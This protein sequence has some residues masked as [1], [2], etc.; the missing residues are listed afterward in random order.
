MLNVFPTL[1]TGNIRDGINITLLKVLSANNYIF[2]D[3]NLS[4]VSQGSDSNRQ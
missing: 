4:S 1:A 3:V 2:P